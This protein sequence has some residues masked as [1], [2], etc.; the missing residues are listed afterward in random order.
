MNNFH[1]GLPEKFTLSTGVEYK[2]D[3]KISYAIFD[4][5]AF[6][7]S[8]IST[9]ILYRGVALSSMIT[10]F[11]VIIKLLVL[12]C[13][14][15]IGVF[16]IDIN[17]WIPYIPQNTGKFGEYGISGI[18]TGV[19]MVF[20]AFNGFDSICTSA[21][22]VKNPKKNI[23][24]GIII[25]IITVTIIYVVTS[26]VMTG[27]VTYQELNVPQALAIA[28]DKIGLP[29]L[30]YI[31][32]FGAVAGLSSVIIVSQYTV[33][34]MLLVMAEDNLLP[35]IF[36]QVHNKNQTPHIITLVIGFSMSFIAATTNLQNIVKLSSFFILL[37]L[38]V[39]CIATIV[40]R[41]NKPELN[42]GFYCPLMPITPTI[43]ILLS[44]YILSSYPIQIYIKAGM[45]LMI[46]TFLYF[47]QKKLNTNK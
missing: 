31:V 12:L 46:L 1:L 39:I 3:G 37:T 10:S 15:S 42:R 38:I 8:F 28:V 33:I 23:P 11:S 6:A 19:S 13:F 29:W 35:S 40:M 26:A 21:Q 36:A 2:V 24:L 22:E 34:R 47:I 27:L 17:N 44:T 20:L 5:P 16:Y 30:N 41:Y 9:L 14:I 43:A 25:T 45:V 4:I 32:K 18:I 7:I